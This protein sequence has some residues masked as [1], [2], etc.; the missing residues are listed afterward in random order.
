MHDHYKQTF[1]IFFFDILY[2]LQ[3]YC[4]CRRDEFEEKIASLLLQLEA[5]LKGLLEKSGND[6]RH[7]L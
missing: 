4:F 3:Y 7:L 1:D 2:L 5:T 6:Y